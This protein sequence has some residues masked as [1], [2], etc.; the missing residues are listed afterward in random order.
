[1]TDLLRL[2]YQRIL[3]YHLLF[4][5]LLKQ[6]DVDHSAKELIEKTKQSMSEVG[7]YLN[8]CQRDKENLSY[9]EQLNK[10]FINNNDSAASSKASSS[11]LY[12]NSFNLNLLK[13]F[14]HYIKDD[15]FIIKSNDSSASTRS[16]FLFEKALIVCKAKG[17][18][19]NY[20]EL[21]LINEYNIEDPQASSA[22]L[23]S[24][25]SSNLMHGNV[26]TGLL[27]NLIASNQNLSTSSIS[28]NS[29]Q[30]SLCLINPDNNAKMYQF[31]FKNKEKK[32]AWK[33]A[34]LTAKSKVKPDGSR[35][36]KHIFELSNFDRELVKC[37]V[38]D[39]YL[40]GIFYQGYKCR[41][42]N[43]RAHKDCLAKITSTCQSVNQPPLDR[44]PTLRSHSS[45]GIIFTLIFTI[46]FF[47]L[48]PNLSFNPKYLCKNIKY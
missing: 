18:F 11:A 6:T 39:K 44:P 30:H 19:Y 42:C 32:K 48:K 31:I 24:A 5:E 36:N 46:F 16:F 4:G 14:G 10:H 15:K 45:L 20:K 29:S 47:L 7:N 8:E 21:I 2:P 25:S 17:N 35:A 40:L 28:L 27:S 43:E 9:I 37:F 34:L 1:M 41:L 12:S 23:S 22:A 33:D 38:C 13:D 26:A 3:K